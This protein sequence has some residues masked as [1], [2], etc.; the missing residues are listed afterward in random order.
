MKEKPYLK[1]VRVV[2]CAAFVLKLPRGS[3]FESLVIEGVDFET[4][5]D[6]VYMVLISD[7]YDIP[8][9]VDSRHVTYDESR[10]PGASAFD[11]YMA[12]ESAP[13][14]DYDV[15]HVSQQNSIAS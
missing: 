8:R 2:R 15:E 13:D 4:M 6:G 3:K 14:S 11:E 1:N 5:K 12:D 9:V 10:F 7:Q